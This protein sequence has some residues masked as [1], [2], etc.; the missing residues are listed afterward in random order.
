[1]AKR[2]PVSD[3]ELLLETGVA[4][5]RSTVGAPGALVWG[6]LGLGVAL[7]LAWYL[8]CPPLWLDEA[9]L[10]LNL[11]RRTAAGLLH[12]LDYNQGAPLGFL[13]ISRLVLVLGGPSEYAL[14]LVPLLAG[15][16]LL[17]LG[18]ALARR[19]LTPA[20]ALLALALLSCSPFLIRYSGEAK[21]Y[22]VDVLVT[23]AL[24][25]LLLRVDPRAVRRRE[26]AQLALFG[27]LALW[28]SHPAAFVLAAGGTA[29]FVAALRARAV[30]SLRRLAAVGTAWVVSLGV[31][32]AV[33]LRDLLHN[34]VLV[35]YWK[36]D[37][38]PTAG[39]HW[40]AAVVHWLRIH[41]WVFDDPGGFGLLPAWVFAGLA[42]VAAVALVATRR[43]WALVL[44]LGPVL[45][46]LAASAARAYP[47]AGRLLLFA[48]PIL[49]ILV[50]EAATL[51]LRVGRPWLSALVCTTV[52][53]A[54]AYRAL[55]FRDSER[56]EI[57]PVLRFVDA[58]AHPGDSLRVL[59]GGTA[60]PVV[61]FYLPRYGLAERGILT[62]D[63]TGRL[64]SPSAAVGDAWVV[65]IPR[66]A[67]TSP[68][69]PDPSLERYR[70]RRPLLA[71]FTFHD[72]VLFRF[73]P[74]R[75]PR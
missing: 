39:G 38:F 1:M 9:S 4:A 33:S 26:A 40:P 30:P 5:T 21:Q 34:G 62:D 52:L 45:L 10:A 25:L 41:V 29:H 58:H 49:V 50:A 14:R 46:A 72:A 12:P 22:S 44:L 59:P 54:T 3:T 51:P 42:A 60:R 68:A 7:R 6:L 31:L 73:G 27:A 69:P 57:R 71:A 8:H 2:D 18:Y 70:E 15:I 11:V 48:V 32:F 20:G 23:L 37:F 17:P 63:G 24:L 53:G 16:A 65:S 47:F 36:D 74:V 67:H 75:S 56:V 61:D 43:T 55:R 13:E 19:I 35:Q 28:L 64:P 66:R